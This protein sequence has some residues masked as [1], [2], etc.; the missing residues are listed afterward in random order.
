MPV[1]P[2]LT[3]PPLGDLQPVTAGRPRE[4]RPDEKTANVK[5]AINPMGPDEQGA[6]PAVQEV[7][8]SDRYK[9]RKTVM[10]ES[11]DTGEH[12]RAR[13]E[14]SDMSGSV[15]KTMYEREVTS[16]RVVNVCPSL[17]EVP[18]YTVSQK[19]TRHLTLAHNFTKY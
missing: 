12:S 15:S 2:E 7:R 13:C 10:H 11:R 18:H 17:A 4:A 1:L 6:A 8:A 9:R 14:S 19:K 3:L 5:S 16:S